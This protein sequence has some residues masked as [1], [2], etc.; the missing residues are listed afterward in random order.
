MESTSMSDDSRNPGG[1]DGVQLGAVPSPTD[2]N[3]VGVE[4]GEEVGP[5][6]LRPV[7]RLISDEASP[8]FFALRFR[9]DPEGHTG[10]G[11]FVAIESTAEDGA[12]VLVIARVEDVH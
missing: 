9:L 7:G 4:M 6:G 12:G 1:S 8:S 10:P 5:G 11:R 2:R 3:T